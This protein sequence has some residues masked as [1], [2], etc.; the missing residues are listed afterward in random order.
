MGGGL[1]ENK[2]ESFASKAGRKGS[3][4]NQLLNSVD[5]GRKA[6]VSNYKVP[7]PSMKKIVALKQAAQGYRSADEG[8]IDEEEVE[9][10]SRIQ[11]T[12]KRN[13]EYKFN[14]ISL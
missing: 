13:N 5:N 1:F 12:E 3:Y 9:R 7:I 4:P 14:E 8:Y 10:W 2:R 11:K 6:K